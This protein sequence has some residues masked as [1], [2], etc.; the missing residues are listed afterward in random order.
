[1]KPRITITL[2]GVNSGTVNRF[3]V[4]LDPFSPPYYMSGEE[5]LSMTA[6]MRATV[7]ASRREQQ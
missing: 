1:M 3:K 5:I 6:E 4:E 2:V 7:Y